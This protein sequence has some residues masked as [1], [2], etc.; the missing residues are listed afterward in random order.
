MVLLALYLP[1]AVLFGFLPLPQ[2][3]FGTLTIGTLPAQCAGL[4]Q[5]AY[6]VICALL[7]I[8]AFAL[9]GG[10]AAGTMAVVA[11]VGAIVMNRFLVATAA[12]WTVIA[13]VALV[14]C[15][16]VVTQRL[17]LATD[18]AHVRAIFTNRLAETKI[19]EILH[20]M[21]ALRLESET[22]TLS[23]LFCRLNVPND[24]L[25]ADAAT[26]TDVL[27]SA[28]KML[29]N[30]VIRNDGFIDSISATGFIAFWNAPLND[31]D[32]ARH[33]CAAAMAMATAMETINERLLAVCTDRNV[34]PLELTVG[35]TSGSAVVGCVEGCRRR[36]SAI[37]SLFQ[38]AF[39][40]QQLATR[41]G[42]AILVNDTTRLAA[43]RDFAFLEV[44]YRELDSQIGPTRLYSLQNNPAARGSPC[45]RALATFHNHLFAAV[46]AHKWKKARELIGQCR[47]LSGATP[48]L[49]DL[50]EARIAFY[51][52]NPPGEGWDGAYRQPPL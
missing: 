32:H 46:G 48:K 15:S 7:V 50:H 43:E 8:V 45:F 40:L 1:A 12:T 22:R 16:A 34:L 42:A 25:A 5:S 36:Y 9:S 29:S 49:Y 17:L 6:L 52:R 28:L 39:C 44:D 21:D 10:L 18:R 47:K 19:R 31:P 26:L 27:S 24:L 38:I 35:I 4:E 3:N 2:T 41:Y 20:D 30:A 51:E 33:A 14:W 13:G 37:G 11:I 23:C